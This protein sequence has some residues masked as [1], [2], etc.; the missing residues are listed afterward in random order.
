MQTVG[1]LIHNSEFLKRLEQ[2]GITITA[3]PLKNGRTDSVLVIR[4]HG[5]SRE[6]ENE[7]KV[8]QIDYVDATCPLVKKN[9]QIIAKE[10]LK[11]KMILLGDEKHP[12]IVA[13]RSY[14]K[15]ILVCN[16]LEQIAELPKQKEYLVLAQTTLDAEFFKAALPVLIGKADRLIV[17]NTICPASQKRQEEAAEIARRSDLVVVVG[18]LNSSNTTKLANIARQHCSYVL[19]TDKLTLLEE[20]LKKFPRKEIKTVGILA[21]AST[22]REDVDLTLSIINKYFQE[23]GD[24]L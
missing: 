14:G 7:L 9:Q 5:I 22:P 13:A 6:L 18:G 11:R 17:Y 1:P 4:T 19:Q 20:E 16:S 12:E 21:G 23:Q 15:E 24:V 8:S 10:S 2:R 3:E